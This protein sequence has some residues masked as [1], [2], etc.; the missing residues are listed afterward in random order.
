MQLPLQFQDNNGKVVAVFDGVTFRYEHPY[1]PDR[2]I[3]IRKLLKNRLLVQMDPTERR[4]QS[5]LLWLPDKKARR[6]QVGRILMKTPTYW[7]YLA[8]EWRSTDEF[9]MGD[10]VLFR[11]VSGMPLY[12]GSQF[13]VWFFQPDSIMALLEVTSTTLSHQM[14]YT[15]LPTSTDEYP[16]DSEEDEQDLVSNKEMGFNEFR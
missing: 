4:T 7:D 2:W 16:E 6:P 10:R 14:P 5:G 9:K 15:E 1:H 11:P 3:T 12:F 8:R 13:E